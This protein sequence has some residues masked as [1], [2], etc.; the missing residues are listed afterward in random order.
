MNKCAC[1]MQEKEPAGRWPQNPELSMQ[2]SGFASMLGRHLIG[3]VQQIVQVNAGISKAQGIS[4][5]KLQQRAARPCAVPINAAPRCSN[6]LSTC[7][8]PAVHVLR[9][10]DPARVVEGRS[11]ALRCLW[12]AAYVFCGLPHASHPAFVSRPP[13]VFGSMHG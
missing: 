11:A 6:C 2:D 7:R 1:R 3:T 8:R 9:L 4:A 5:P 12:L 13:R 10:V